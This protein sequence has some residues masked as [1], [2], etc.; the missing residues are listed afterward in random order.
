MPS[1]TIGPTRRPTLS[2]AEKPFAGAWLSRSKHLR[3][4][5]LVERLSDTLKILNALQRTLPVPQIAQRKAGSLAHQIDTFVA[6]ATAPYRLPVA[7]PP[8]FPRG[9]DHATITAAL[10]ERLAL[11]NALDRG[12]TKTNN[13]QFLERAPGVKPIYPRG[14]GEE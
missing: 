6:S 2:R 11:L 7:A 3:L 10:T 5:A 4:E 1:T 8:P 14:S 12:A 13:R 9:T